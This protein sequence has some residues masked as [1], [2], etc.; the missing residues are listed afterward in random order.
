MTI[1]TNRDLERMASLQMNWRKEFL[2]ELVRLRQQRDNTRDRE[3]LPSAEATDIRCSADEG[4]TAL[5]PAG[6]WPA[7]GQPRN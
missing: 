3:R 5:R 2:R 4:R 7:T 1:F 6:S